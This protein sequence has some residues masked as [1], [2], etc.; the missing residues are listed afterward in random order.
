[1]PSGS[2]R[3]SRPKPSEVAAET[4][5][6]YIPHIRKNYSDTWKLF[7]Y[8]Y[9]QPLQLPLEGRPANVAA[10]TFYVYAGDPVDFA[11]NWSAS[12][13]VRVGFICSANDKRAGGDWETGS[14]GYEEKLCRR[15]TLSANLSM[16]GPGSLVKE[17]Y[18]IP[19]EGG[20]YSDT[21]VVFRGPHDR[22]ES[23]QPDQWRDLPVISVPPER[24]PKLNQNG[25][26]YSFAEERQLVR[27]KLRAALWICAYNH[28]SNVVIG[29]F[30][31]G[32]GYRNPPQEMAELWREVFLYDP[33]LRG[34]I[35][36]AAFVFE[37]PAQSTTRL[38]LEDLAKKSKGGSGSGKGKSKASSS[39]HSSSSSSAANLN[40]LSTPTDLAIFQHVFEPNEIQRYQSQTDPRLGLGNL[41]L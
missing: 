10:P 36:S 33:E 26:K 20:I 31:L 27:N 5:K 9:E 34:R 17:N 4:K 24:W 16:A 1:M 6:T 25:T 37:D 41:V 38:I 8:L 11:L 15:S 39:S 23:L 35:A 3:S 40:G 2:S 22:Y 29:D 28:I 18:P 14:A 30:G 12:R 19:I 32:N 13:D 21:V 7:S